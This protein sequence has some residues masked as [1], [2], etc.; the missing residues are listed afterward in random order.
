MYTKRI[1]AILVILSLILTLATLAGCDIATEIGEGFLENIMGIDD[2]LPECNHKV[3]KWTL[4][5][6]ESC[7]GGTFIGLCTECDSSVKRT[8]TAEDHSWGDTIVVN[9][10]CL[11]GGYDVKVCSICSAEDRSNLTQ[12]YGHS[13]TVDRHEATCENAG[14]FILSC[15]VCTY[16]ERVEGDPALRHDFSSEYKFDEIG[17]Y[18]SC[19]RCGERS[20]SE[21]HSYGDNNYCIYC[22]I[23]SSA[24]VYDVTIWVSE[25]E[26]VAAQIKEQI[27]AF[28][29]D[30]P[31]IIINATIACV[32][33]ANAGYRITSDVASAPDIYCFSQDWLARLVSV[34]ALAAPGA[35][36]A[37]EI[38]A[39]NEASSVAA[40]T[41]GGTVYAY[42][43][44]SDNGYFMYYDTSIISPE[45]AESLGSLIA[46]C[47]R[48]NVKL[49]F[50]LENAWYTASFFFATG[51]HSNWITNEKGEFIGV[52]DNFNSEAGLIAMKGMQMLTQSSCYHPDADI[53]T[54]A[55]VVITGIWNAEA[56]AYHFGANLGATDLPSFTVDGQT[57][58]L[59][60]YSGQK[61]IGVKP[62]DNAER[63]A[64]LSLLAQYLTNE[65]CQTERYECFNWLPSNKAAQ[66]SDAI[67]AN[68][69]FAAVLK[70]NEYATPQGNICGIWWDIARVLGADA[71]AAES[72][73]DLQSALD[74]YDA[75]I[76]LWL[77]PHAS[78]SSW[79]VIGSVG[80]TRWDADFAMTEEPAGTWTSVEIVMTAGEEFKVR[81]GLDWTY[82]YGADGVLGGDNI[83]VETT[84][85]YKVQLVIS[86]DGSVTISLIPV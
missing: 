52:D 30:N 84:G 6:G 9:P 18:R 53:F 77:N 4:A 69:T 5:D 73:A 32:T 29:A 2:S 58:H 36:F 82:N 50:D 61:L 15:T 81:K 46:A 57:Y 76:E 19:S 17:H 85:T 55:G 25:K 22:G 38:I 41:L 86:E 28:M 72:E 51:C 62:Q 10:T 66:A 43:M 47:E 14:Y 48:N 13:V 40:A 35:P 3:S 65:K 16:V 21:P 49:R 59:G 74:N 33:E 7:D 26:G 63:E 78:S 34:G 67:Q 1:K 56:A 44:T 60:S 71:K 24:E 39:S 42:P 8:G 12:R 83:V 75:N 20:E 23:E 80:G 45:E 31:G 70:Q 27:R 68:V 37:E 79:T 11:D 64:A 54:D